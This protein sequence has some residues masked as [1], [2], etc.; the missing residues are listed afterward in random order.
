MEN[1][2]YTVGLTKPRPV[3]GR[4]IMYCLLDMNGYMTAEYSERSTPH[5]Y[6]QNSSS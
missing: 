3:V 4:E 2:T 1:V 6:P 5:V